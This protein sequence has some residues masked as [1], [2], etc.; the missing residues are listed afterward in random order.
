MYKIFLPS[1]LAVQMWNVDAK[2]NTIVP[3]VGDVISQANA[4]T[5]EVETVHRPIDGFLSNL[6]HSPKI[7]NKTETKSPK[8]S[9]PPTSVQ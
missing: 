6:R 1:L 7:Q 9:N 2:L 4:Y 3:P 8:N 5:A